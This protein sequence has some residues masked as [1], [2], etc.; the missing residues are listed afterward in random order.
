MRKLKEPSK[1]A[2]ETLEKALREKE[3]A[4]KER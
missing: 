3:Y 1:V 2:F 4:E